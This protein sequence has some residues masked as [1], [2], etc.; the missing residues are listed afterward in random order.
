MDGLTTDFNGLIMK[1]KFPIQNENFQEMNC[2]T[3]E[4]KITEI[5]MLS[6]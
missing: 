6:P 4:H 3:P 2:F 1:S 5:D